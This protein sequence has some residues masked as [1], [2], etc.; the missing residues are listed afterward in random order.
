MCHDFPFFFSFSRK[1]PD[2]RASTW[3]VSRLFRTFDLASR[4]QRIQL[5]SRGPSPRSCQ[6][7]HKGYAEHYNNVRRGSQRHW[8]A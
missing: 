7:P 6:V 8:D 1:L 2:A 4:F 5:P 3:V